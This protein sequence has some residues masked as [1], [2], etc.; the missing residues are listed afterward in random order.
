MKRRAFTMMELIFVI[1]I[2][3]IIAK[4][5]VEM[6]IKAYDNYVFSTVENRLE[7]STAFAL[8]EIANR[9]SYR[10][11]PSVIVRKNSTDPNFIS[12]ASYQPGVYP[13]NSKAILEWIGYDD[14]GFRGSGN[15]AWNKPDWSGF[16]DLDNPKHTSSN[17]IS[18]ETNT[19]AENDVIKA[20]SGGGTDINDSAIYFIGGDTN[21][22]GFGWGGA[23]ANQKEV[24]H[25]IESNSTNINILQ[26]KFPS[27]ND[28]NGTRVYEFY[29]LAWSAYALVYSGTNTSQNIPYIKKLDNNNSN[30]LFGNVLPH[31]LK[32]G[33]GNGQWSETTTNHYVLHISGKDVPFTYYDENGTFTCDTSSPTTGT[34]CKGLIR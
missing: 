28:F 14:A 34:I 10:I 17:L 2:I 33:S 7:Q 19:T 1:V 13:K 11:K 23:I 9:L 24:M 6:L 8:Q 29:Q 3:G 5:G 25:P 26:S 22:H 4:F 21:I 30:N 32:A 31:G 18:P 12:L 27:P 20:L 15:G 16:I